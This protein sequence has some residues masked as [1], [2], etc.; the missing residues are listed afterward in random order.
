MAGKNQGKK[1][2]AV[3]RRPVTRKSGFSSTSQLRIRRSS[4]KALEAGP[5]N[6]IIL[7]FTIPKTKSNQ[8]VGWSGYLFAPTGTLITSDSTHGE[9]FIGNPEDGDWVKFGGLWFEEF[10]SNSFSIR[11]TIRPP[12]DTSIGIYEILS[13]I[14][15][16]P[17]LFNSRSGLLKGMYQYSPEANFYLNPISAQLETKNL[18]SSRPVT[19]TTKSC[20]RC[21][22]FLPINEISEIHHLAFTNHCKARRPCIHPG[23]GLLSEEGNE[24]NVVQFEYGFQ[25]ECRFCKKFEVNG[26]LNPQRTTGQMKEDGAR[27]RHFELLLEY[28]Y[29]GSPQLQYKRKFG[30]ELA[31]DIW[32][33]FD[34][35]C[36][37][38]GKEVFV[39]SNN[40]EGSFNLDHTRPL[41]LLWPL[42][43]TATCLCKGCNSS[44]RDR[45]PSDFYSDAELKR[46]AK[47]TGIS[48]KD[49]KNPQPNIDALKLIGARREWLMNEFLQLP[50]LQKVRD[51]KKT[52]DLVLKALNRVIDICAEP[53]PIGKFSI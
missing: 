18:I 51:G 25:L 31:V 10:E 20:N 13:G 48:L 8:W 6:P 19:L 11:L 30:R 12:R 3:Q 1:D 24:S 34:Q 52:S 23:F 15:E 38:C 42:D 47:L 2:W 49:L 50:E 43:E 22:R 35:K 53:K 36:F 26:A 33:K 29:Q 4:E 46:L 21:G 45:A 44:K 7:N 39:D 40:P 17:H 28:L 14:V 41:A 5:S 16:H 32:E 37:K 27:R 9:S